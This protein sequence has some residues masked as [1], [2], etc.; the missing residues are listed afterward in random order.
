[1]LLCYILSKNSGL[2]QPFYYT[3]LTVLWVKN[4]GGTWLFDSSVSHGVDG[5]WV[6]GVP[7]E[8]GGKG[9]QARRRPFQSCH[10]RWLRNSRVNVACRQET[11]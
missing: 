6:V 10:I 4:S 3:Y 11:V 2:K 8:D 1:M 5:G 9:W 7:L